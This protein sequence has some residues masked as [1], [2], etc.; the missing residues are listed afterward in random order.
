MDA[1]IPEILGLLQHEEGID[2]LTILGGEPL[3]QPDAVLQLI[4]GVQAAGLNVV[5]YTGYEVDEL[6]GSALACARETDLLI[7]GR[8]VEELRSTTLRW[9][10][11]TN[12]T[13]TSP[14]GRFNCSEIEEFGEAEFH[15]D[16]ATGSVV[17]LGY[18]D[19]AMLDA[20]GVTRGRTPVQPSHES[21]RRRLQVV[22]ED[23]P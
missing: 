8:Y 11:S 16:E 22:R 6:N 2:G 14:T 18:P 7:S 15:I 23:V 21:L 4:R 13:I 10:G 9:R 17:A 3:Q 19:D 12:Q 20:I 5:L 1:S